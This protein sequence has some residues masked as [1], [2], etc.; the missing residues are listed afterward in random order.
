MSVPTAGM[1]LA[2]RRA[3]DE[4]RRA[5]AATAAEGSVAAD[6]SFTRTSQSCGGGQGV[7]IE[8]R[9]VGTGVV[10]YRESVLALSAV[11]DLS[12]SRVS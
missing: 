1:A 9:V 11:R 6:V 3:E 10:R 2:R 5:L 7:L 8:G 4:V 12:G